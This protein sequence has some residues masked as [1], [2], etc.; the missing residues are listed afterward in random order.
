MGRGEAAK[1]DRELLDYLKNRQIDDVKEV[2]ANAK[3]RRFVRY[4]FKFCG[5]YQSSVGQGNDQTNI[6][7]GR[8]QVGL[9]LLALLDKADPNLRM[10][11]EREYLS[12]YNGQVTQHKKAKKEA[13]RA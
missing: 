10:Q 4:I 9:L 1:M 3:G 6:N 11:I 2:C 12:E 13:A 7:E 8:R 5:V